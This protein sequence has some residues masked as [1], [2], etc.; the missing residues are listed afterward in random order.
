MAPPRDYYKALGV[1]KGASDAE[2]KRAYRKLARQLHPD[3]TGDDPKSTERFKMI[4]E[5]YEVLSDPKR[6]RTYDLFGGPSSSSAPDPPF[7]GF[8][9][10][11]QDVLRRNQKRGAAGGK[12]PGIDIERTVDVTLAEAATG[13]EKVVE[14]DLL[15]PCSACDGKGYPKDKPPETCPECS[16]SGTKGGTFPLKRTCPRCE[17]AGTIRRYTCKTCAGDGSK[18][19]QE[20]LKI[21]VPAGV[22]T[23]TKLR[24]K[25]RG[26]AGRNGGEPGDLYAVID[27]RDDPRFE[28]DGV[29]L[30]T[31]LRIGIKDALLGARVDVPLPDG[32]ALMTIPAGTQG[33]QI[34]RIRGR[35]M[36]KLHGSADHNHAQHGDVLVTVQV[37]VPK[38]L[39]PDA[40]ALVEQLAATVPEL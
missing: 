23:G 29:H 22:D 37:R 10:A 39:S 16:G 28:R 3:V 18:R 8:A 24:M 12:E 31:T 38:T 15:R 11:V 30:K 2:I 17:G 9:D 1:S 40:K 19:E 6:R 13:C 33:G 20:R 34:F 21:T 27:I 7:A 26:E 5:A 4:T 32:T 35:G 25:G 14:L 36:P